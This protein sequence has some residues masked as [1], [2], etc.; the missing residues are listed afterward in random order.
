MID[1]RGYVPPTGS[2]TFLRKVDVHFGRTL[3]E[4]LSTDHGPKLEM[5]SFALLCE[6]LGT[7]LRK[8]WKHR[9]ESVARFPT[10][11][12]GRGRTR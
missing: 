2:F 11:S 4:L 5:K 8:G 10:M 12:R 3:R 7:F 1:A 6:S 9:P